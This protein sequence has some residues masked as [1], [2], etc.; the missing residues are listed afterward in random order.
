M[1]G[2]LSIE[3]LAVWFYTRKGIAR[4]INGVHLTVEEG[5]LLG[6][7]GESGS[8]K[9]VLANALLGHVAEPGRIVQGKV[10]YRGT[11]LRTL[12]EE[13]LIR[14]YRGKEIGLIA[15]NARAHLNPLMRVGDL[16]A[17]I[18]LSH[19]GGT[20]REARRMAVEMLRA[21]GINDPENRARSY[22]HELSGGMA[23]RVMIALALINSPRLLIADD[24]TNGLDVTVAAQ[25]MDLFMEMFSRS[26]SSG[27][28]ITHDLGLVAQYCR[29]IAIM[30]CGQI[31]ERAP[32]DRFFQSPA[33]PYSIR[34]LEALPERRKGRRDA[35]GI[36]RLPSP[37][38]L[39]QGCLYHPRCQYAENLCRAEEPPMSLIG[40]Q[41]YLK[42][43]DP[44]SRMAVNR[45][46][47][48]ETCRGKAGALDG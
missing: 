38:E 33:H 21:V 43:H 8:G 42:C 10:I 46:R 30:Y 37:L 18:A 34:L 4:V 2:I 9:T 32:V 19:Q 44:A 11:D 13:E 17:D 20:Q 39:P 45:I 7:V 14:N 12:G 29:S 47:E 16:I 5:E 23:Q 3:D 48:V 35:A 6:L 25:V 41:F 24:C 15:S 40:E 27:V 1:N 31:I 26:G 28:L 22:P 36:G